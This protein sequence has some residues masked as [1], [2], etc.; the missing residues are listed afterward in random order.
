MVL[1]VALLP[2]IL[3]GA[4]H[5]LYEI[6]CHSMFFLFP[7]SSF[8]MLYINSFTVSLVALLPLISWMLFMCCMRYWCHSMFF[9]FVSSGSFCYAYHINSFHSLVGSSVTLDIFGTAHAMYEK[10]MCSIFFLFPL[11]LTNSFV[12]CLSM[13]PAILSWSKVGT[14]VSLLHSDVHGRW[15]LFI[16][17]QM[18]TT[19][20][21]L[22]IRS[23]VLSSHH[24][25]CYVSISMFSHY[26]VWPMHSWRLSMST[27]PG[28]R[29]S[30]IFRA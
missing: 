3:L 27:N 28:G 7:L 17:V 2:S 21:L 9:F 14:H 11:A 20:S 1:L 6:S 8:V 10:S 5:A 12:M 18:I 13:C 25:F 4:V 23:L 15:L 30:I 22:Q 26:L 24:P 19:W 16:M 29:Q